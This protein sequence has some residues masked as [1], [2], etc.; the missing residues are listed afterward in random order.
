MAVARDAAAGGCARLR[1]PR[2][3]SRGTTLADAM[4]GAAMRA[5]VAACL[6]ACVV[7]AGASLVAIDLGSD[8]LKVALIKPGRTPI[9]IVVNEMSRRKSPALVGVVNGER[10]LGEEA[11]SI[12]ARYPANVFQRTKDLLGRRHNDTYA[13]NLVRDQFLPYSLVED[14]RLKVASI[15][16]SD[17]TTVTMQELVVS[18]R[19][20]KIEPYSQQPD[21]HHTCRGSHMTLIYGCIA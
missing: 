1:Q 6:V 7:C 10:V 16:L 8:F 12:L 11:A 4:G 18:R 3:K 17:G 2:C 5:L 21:L 19:S 14:A 20:R 13:S 15:A 9:S